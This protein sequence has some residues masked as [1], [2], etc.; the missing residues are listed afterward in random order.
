MFK[1]LMLFIATLALT[2]P[3][4]LAETASK[5]GTP[6]EL[7]PANPGDNSSLRTDWEYNTGGAIDTVP[8]T[9]GSHDGWGEWFITSVQNTSGQDVYLTEFG[10][11]CCGPPTETFGWVVW[12]GTA[13]NSPPSGNAYT[14][15][16]YGAF[17]PVDSNPS[18]FPPTTY[19]YIDVAAEAIVIP[20]G[21]W[22]VFGYDVTGN[23]GQIPYNG[24]QTWA[25]YSGTWDPDPGWGRTAI[26]QVKG[27][28]EPP[29]LA[30]LNTWGGIKIL[31]CQ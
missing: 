31:Y 16:F 1:W 10:F 13:P 22:F 26:L 29:I 4:T 15:H 8:T 19:T 3:G 11:P 6:V 9:G 7:N 14:A 20:D 25:W 30:E 18:T 5:D 24:V 12:V 17:T 23:G 27:S 2:A 21:V 28:F